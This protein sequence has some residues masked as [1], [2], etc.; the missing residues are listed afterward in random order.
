MDKQFRTTVELDL[1]RERIPVEL[2]FGERK[3]LTLS[4]H[5]DRSITAI[6]PVGRSV[7]E[8][9]AHLNRR[10]T[11]IVRQRNHFEKYLP[12]PEPRR[13][14]SGETHYYLGRQYRLKVRSADRTGVKLSGGYL[15]VWTPTPDK[16]K[17]SE[18]ALSDWYRERAEAVFHARMERLLEAAPA[19]K[20]ES[21]R[22]RVRS[23]RKNWGTCSPSG[24]IT[25]NTHLIKVPSHCID[26]VIAHELC[27]LKFHNHSPAF[28][29]L[30]S[31]YIPD[32]KTRKERLEAMPILAVPHTDG[33]R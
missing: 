23:M 13:Y 22:L 1:G 11:W 24:T 18:A 32:W 9:M 16:P 30:L 31:R 6:A 7:E 8:V 15:H 28:Y 26:Y 5:P 10:R 21:L 29:R 2:S 4:V 19:L 17:K 25:L 20:S 3:R 12:A 14:V 33:A 27:H